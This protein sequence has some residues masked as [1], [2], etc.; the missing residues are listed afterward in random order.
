MGRAGEEVVDLGRFLEPVEFLCHGDAKLLL[1][2]VFVE[3]V[4]DGFE[5]RYLRLRVAQALQDNV[6]ITDVEDAGQT[7]YA[8][9]FQA[10]GFV[11]DDRL[12]AVLADRAQEFFEFKGDVADLSFMTFTAPATDYAKKAIPATIHVDGTARIQTVKPE[13]NQPYANVIRRFG[14]LTGVPVVLN[15]S[16]NDKAEPIVETPEHAIRT[17]LNTDL[18]LLCIG[19]VIAWKGN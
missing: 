15:T 3:F 1:V 5:V 14:E 19:N 12:P 9:R 16:F 4:L 2:D 17:F 10:K 18:D 6:F 7:F 13:L 8:T 11:F